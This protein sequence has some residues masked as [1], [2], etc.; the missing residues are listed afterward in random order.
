MSWQDRLYKILK[1]DG[2]KLFSYVPDAGHKILIDNATK[3]NSVIAIPL[4]SCLAILF[5]ILA[6][7]CNSVYPLSTILG[8]KGL[9]ITMPV[10]RDSKPSQFSC[11]MLLLYLIIDKMSSDLKEVLAQFHPKSIRCKQGH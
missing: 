9:G 1:N 5:N 6:S 8:L 2:I 7:C 3:D 4:D 10:N 11:F